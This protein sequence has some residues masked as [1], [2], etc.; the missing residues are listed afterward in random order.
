M[1]NL[2]RNSLFLF[3]TSALSLLSIHPSRAGTAA[4]CAL[5]VPLGIR[6]KSL[7]PLLVLGIGGTLLDMGVG[8]YRC[9]GLSGTVAEAR[10]RGE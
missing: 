7:A 9:G 4:G 10:R 8:I 3:S 2:G 5:A 6:R 1:G